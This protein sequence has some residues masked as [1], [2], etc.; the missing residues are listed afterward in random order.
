MLSLSGGG[1]RAM[2]SGLTFIDEIEKHVST[3]I[4]PVMTQG[5]SG[6]SWGVLI[7]EAVG[8]KEAMEMFHHYTDEGKK[9]GDTAI[10][11][12]TV[13]ASALGL[14]DI[15]KAH[16]DWKKMVWVTITDPLSEPAKQFAF[17]EGKDGKAQVLVGVTLHENHDDNWDTEFKNRMC[18]AS[19]REG[20]GLID[21]HKRW[22]KHD[23]RLKIKIDLYKTKDS[24][25]RKLSDM[26]FFADPTGEKPVWMKTRVEQATLS[27]SAFLALKTV[28]WVKWGGETTQDG[29][30]IMLYQGIHV[31]VEDSAGA[32][33]AGENEGKP[34]TKNLENPV[35]AGFWDLGIRC[36]LAVDPADFDT[37]GTTLL[38]DAHGDDPY[39]IHKKYHHESPFF[40]FKA[41][42][43]YWELWD[44]SCVLMD[45]KSSQGA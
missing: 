40:A 32:D 17:K 4:E 35:K 15:W 38:M 11:G 21:C 28:D 26:Q 41:C 45:T 31:D 7:N 37:P 6:G 34:S 14:G 2:L 9:I 13:G 29:L 22:K 20:F 27:S 43:K 25:E 18:V 5:L 39:N 19:F 42:E 24:R 16:D 3:K 36:N 33:E 1:N 8:A 44:Y 30:A 12:M 23:E 10:S